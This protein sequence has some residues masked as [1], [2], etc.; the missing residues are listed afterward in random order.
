MW[1]Y[2]LENL[3]WFIDKLFTR[4]QTFTILYPKDIEELLQIIA[5]AKDN[6]STMKIVGE[7]L[8][9]NYNKNDIIVSLVNLNKLLGLDT[10]NK[11][12]TVEAGMKLSVLSSILASVNLC[13]DISGRIPDL[14][15]C[16]CLAV[17]GPGIGCGS[18]GLGSSII[19]LQVITAG[20]EV[21]S[22]SWD[23]QTRQMAGLV[24]GLGM[25][26]LIIA[27]TI[28]CYPMMLVRE[29]SYLANVRDVIES[30]Q[31]LHRTSDHQ[32]VTW[33]P[34]TELV[35]IKHTSD[36]DI[37][38]MSSCQSRLHMFL[39]EAS[40][41]FAY[42]IRKIN[43]NCIPSVSML[44]CLLARVQFISLWTSSRYRS[45]HALPPAQFIR[46]AG[47]IMRGTT[48]LLPSDTIPCVLHN[49]ST[50]SQHYPGHVTSPIFIQTLHEMSHDLDTMRSS[51]RSRT[52]SVGSSS[53]YRLSGSTPHGLHGQG[54]LCP[55]LEKHSGPLA[56][57]WYDWF[58]PET[59][60]D[61]LQVGQLEEIF[62]QSSHVADL[63]PI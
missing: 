37:L 25:V 31:M 56:T 44:S 58:L 48:W 32:Q 45:D 59:C 8:H 60:P 50:W 62:L 22:W 10:N 39:A 49:I 15:I 42:I 52:S 11:S 27:V 57:V 51:V 17:S 18:T 26:A 9:T 21:V 5:Q 46:P 4:S 1:L 43:I 16:D 40:E 28:Q 35:I 7:S 12:V 13:L 14:T 41:W 6:S 23:N 47:S 29:I 63:D 24:G 19:S 61:P 55:R 36:L 33:F 2:L 53:H 3:R 54:Y 20:G 38:R 34:F 30:W